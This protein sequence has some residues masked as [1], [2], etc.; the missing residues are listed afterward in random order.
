MILIITEE[1][2]YSSSMVIDWLLYYKIDFIR[3]NENDQLNVEFLLNDIKIMNDSFSFLLSELKGMWYRRGHL[4]IKFEKV[5]DLIIDNFKKT[6]FTKLNQYIY[7]KLSLL[8]NINIFNNSDVNK[9][10]VNDIAA[11]FGLTVPYEYI[12]SLGKELHLLHNLEEYATKS[13]S[14][15]AI[16]DFENHYLIGYTTLLKKEKKY[17]DTFSPSLIQKYIKKKYELRI[18]Y[19]HKKFYSMAIFSQND[20]TT[21]VDFRNYNRINP[22][23][24][25]PFELP[26]HIKEKLINLMERLKLNS[27]SIDM[28]VTPNNEFVFLEVNPIGQYGMVSNPCNYYLDRQIAIFYKE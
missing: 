24:N 22:N 18:F 28:I 12:L 3:V 27:G 8:P 23:R 20:E 7:Y 15:S 9:L 19:L 14:G 11:K 10:I 5:G 13:I 26:I 25:V 21:E 16:L 4:N 6:E 17:S 2:D 1:A